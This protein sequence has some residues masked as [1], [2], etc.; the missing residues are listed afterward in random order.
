MDLLQ[1]LRRHRIPPRK[2]ITTQ[3]DDSSLL[4]KMR[5][6]LSISSV[7]P[8]LRDS[9]WSSTPNRQ[10]QKQN[11]PSRKPLN[12]R[13][14]TVQKEKLSVRKSKQTT[15][16]LCD[17]RTSRLFVRNTRPGATDHRSGFDSSSH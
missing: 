5:N 16:R 17:R 10:M 15:S 6:I 2:K 13:E 7:L 14:K 4:G 3:S 8:L 11:S 12:C 1:V 9:G